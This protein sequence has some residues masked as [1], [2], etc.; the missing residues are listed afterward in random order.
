MSL[1]FVDKQV[2]EPF[3]MFDLPDVDGIVEGA[4]V[5]ALDDGIEYYAAPKPKKQNKG[6]Y[7]LLMLVG[8]AGV[9][10]GAYCLM[11]SQKK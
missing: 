5:A 8:A 6:L 2:E 11:Q 4:D 1:H 7:Q 3:A 10:F 9:I